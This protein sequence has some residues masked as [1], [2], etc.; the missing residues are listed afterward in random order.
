[1]VGRVYLCSNM[2]CGNSSRIV[3][4]REKVPQ[5]CPTCG[6]ESLTEF[7][8]AGQRSQKI[9]GTIGKVF[10][11]GLISM[12]S[13]GLTKETLLPSTEVVN[14]QRPQIKLSNTFGYDFDG[15]G[16]IDSAYYQPIGGTPRVPS[17][18]IPLSQASEEFRRLQ[19]AY[20]DSKIKR[21][22]V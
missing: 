19:T 2:N 21:D 11:T 18:R 8:A 16:Q 9:I 13:I 7:V 12:L 22:N 3:Q 6:D 5:Y 4:K 17:W 1:M 15:D 14:G 20:S 10:V